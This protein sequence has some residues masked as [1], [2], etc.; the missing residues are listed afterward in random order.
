M[1]RPEAPGDVVVLFNANGNLIK[2]EPQDLLAEQGVIGCAES[3]GAALTGSGLRVELVPI[4][5]DV[6]SALGPYPPHQWTVFNLGEGLAGRLLE[7]ARIAWALEAMGYCFT[8]SPGEA[9]ARSVNK[10]R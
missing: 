4:R 1:N 8:G 6:E 5:D 10:E 2:G 9:I 7:E 3:I